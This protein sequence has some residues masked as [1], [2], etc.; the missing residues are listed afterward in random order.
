MQNSLLEQLLKRGDKIY[1]Y[2]GSLIIEPISGGHVPKSWLKQH[3]STLVGQILQAVNIDCFA[4]IGYS[5]GKYGGR[6]Y[7][8]VTLQFESLIAREY[9]HCIFNARTD[10][11]CGKKIGNP[12]PKGRFS[13]SKHSTFHKFWR[14]TGLRLPPRLGAFNDYMGNL[15]KLLFTATCKC[16]GKID[17]NSIKPLNVTYEQITASF[18]LLPTNTNQT[19]A[20]QMTNHSQT[21]LPNNDLPQPQESIGLHEFQSTCINNYGI[22]NKDSAVKGNINS[23]NK[24]SSTGNSE[25]T[26]NRYKKKVPQEQT[27]EEW[28][29]DYDNGKYV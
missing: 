6:R 15:K 5:T 12:L 18:A 11:Q 27:N 24:G 14:D 3:G 2:D 25:G 26:I 19:G 17:K 22:S 16:K 13:V 21:L 4:Y 28:L 1:I 8:G 29:E 10:Y 7:S 9:K 23:N 20:E